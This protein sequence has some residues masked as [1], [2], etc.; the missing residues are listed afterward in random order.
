VIPTAQASKFHT[1][2]LPVLCVIFQ[3]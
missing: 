2:V 3:V 1:A